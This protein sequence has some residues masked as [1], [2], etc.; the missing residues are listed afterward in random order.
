M[1]VTNKWTFYV[2]KAGL[3]RSR[4]LQVGVGSRVRWE[5]WEGEGGHRGAK[6]AA[7]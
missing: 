7:A 3:K 6:A 2:K 4:V 5:G 1:Q